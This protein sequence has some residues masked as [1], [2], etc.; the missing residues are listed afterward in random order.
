MVL[1]YI[2]IFQLYSVLEI[3]LVLYL[4]M[5]MINREFMNMFVESLIQF[6]IGL[7]GW[8]IVGVVL[9]L[10]L[11]TNALY[12]PSHVVDR[13][14]DILVE[15]SVVHSSS[16]ELSRTQLQGRDHYSVLDF[17]LSNVPYS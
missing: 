15:S 10:C 11:S 8:H 14:C 3:V 12:A 2:S 7:S 6:W 4:D 5:N 16:I 9:R 13:G 1:Q 17:S